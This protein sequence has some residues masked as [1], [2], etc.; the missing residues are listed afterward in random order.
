MTARADALAAVDEG[1][2][3]GAQGGRAPRFH[4]IMRWGGRL[5]GLVS[6]GLALA[7]GFTAGAADKTLTYLAGHEPD[8]RAILPDPPGPGTPEQAAD[9]ATVV[10]VHGACTTNEAAAAFARRSSTFLISRR[11][12]GLISRRPI[13]R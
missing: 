4:K 6:L 10:A 12:W 2:R 9:M 11:Q 7:G 3:C 8:A 13:C 5:V 1:V